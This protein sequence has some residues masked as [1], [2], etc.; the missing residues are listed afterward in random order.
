[1]LKKLV[2]EGVGPAKLREPRAAVRDS[3]PAA[4]NLPREAESKARGRIDPCDVAAGAPA[5][6]AAEQELL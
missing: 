1:V 6:H 5:M 3:T 2:L 4:S